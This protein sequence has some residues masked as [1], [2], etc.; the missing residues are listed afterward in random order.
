MRFLSFPCRMRSTC[1]EVR[2]PSVAL[3]LLA[4]FRFHL[5]MPR[6]RSVAAVFSIFKKL[7]FNCLFA[8]VMAAVF[9]GNDWLFSQ[10]QEKYAFA[11]TFRR[12]F[13]FFLFLILVSLSYRNRFVF[14]FF[15]L[16]SLMAFSEMLHLNIYGSLL[17]PFTYY[18]LLRELGEVAVA[19]GEYLHFALVPLCFLAGMVASSWMATKWFGK[20]RLRIRYF[21]LFVVFLFLFLPVRSYFTKDKFGARADSHASLFYNSYSTLSYFV[22]HVVPRKAFASNR[23]AT[24]DV[25]IQ[26]PRIHRPKPDVNFVLVLGESLGFKYT[27]LFGYEKETTPFLKSMTKDDRFIHKKAISCGVSTDVAVPTYLNMACEL[28]ASV[29]IAGEKTC[30]FKMAKENG[31]G[32]YFFSAQ[33]GDSLK[34]LI[35]YYCPKYIDLFRGAFEILGKRDYYTALRDKALIEELDRVDFSKSNFIVL[36]QRTSHIPYE[37]NYPAEFDIFK[38][39]NGTFRE[40]MRNSFLNSIRYTDSFLEEVFRYLR[41]KAE[42]KRTYLMFFS[43]HGEAMGEGGRWGHLQLYPEQYEVPFFI[44]DFQKGPPT[45]LM[46]KID[47][48]K[49]FFTF[50]QIA[51]ISAYILGYNRDF[52]SERNF[53]YV[54]GRDLEGFDGYLEIEFEGEN[55]TKIERKTAE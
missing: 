1:T 31:F 12:F 36:Q 38:K 21:F 13:G 29:R 22:S 20:R 9:L 48:R 6:F 7:C 50:N 11:F 52:F 28:G 16:S 27:S 24:S 55:V 33:S 34:G 5:I 18:V 46:R 54:I 40:N 43:D 26:A 49:A 45:P 10:Y 8:I 2:E 4:L 3:F 42:K 47:E 15:L 25:G 44:Y 19:S 17:S 32:T 53:T 51:Q 41:R 30:L 37:S 39:E 14:G 23:S 35:N